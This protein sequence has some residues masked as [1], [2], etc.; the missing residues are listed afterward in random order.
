MSLATVLTDAVGLWRHRS[1]RHREISFPDVSKAPPDTRRQIRDKR[2][3]WILAKENDLPLDALSKDL[4][5]HALRHEM[6]M[7]PGGKVH[8]AVEVLRSTQTGLGFGCQQDQ[9]AEIES[10][11]IDRTCVTNADFAKFVKSDGYSN[12]D[13]WPETILPN[14]LQF[15]D[16]TGMPGPRFWINGEPLASRLNHPVVGINWYEA[17]AYATWAGKRLPSGDEWQRA[18]TWAKTSSGDLKESRYPWGNSFDPLCANVWSS[19]LADTVAVDAYSSGDTP[20][21]VHQ[22]IGNVWEWINSQFYPDCGDGVS[23]LSPQLM[24]EVRG[25]AFDTY[26][27]TQATCQFR[28]GQPLLC[29]SNNLGF[30]CCMSVDSLRDESMSEQEF[31]N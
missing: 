25:G 24:A 21:G 19:G 22:L 2:Y 27:A 31:E 12:P 4:A 15:T 23:M 20:S 6:A 29:R 18:G 13:Y 30:R 16:T 7:V 5:W 1:Q 28:S 26:F 14:L 17:N 3:C 8:R 11:Y 9:I 10:F